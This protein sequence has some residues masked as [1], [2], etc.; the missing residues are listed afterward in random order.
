MPPKVAEWFVTFREVIRP[1][2]R[3]PYTNTDLLFVTTRGNKVAHLATDIISI[4]KEMEL[5][6]I[7][8]PM[9][10]RK[11]NATITAEYA[12]DEQKRLVVT[13]MAHST[14]TAEM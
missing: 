7:M 1:Q 4:A 12:N 10:A 14:K 11:A 5:K 6:T 3:Y 13:H 8:T 2:L 9:A